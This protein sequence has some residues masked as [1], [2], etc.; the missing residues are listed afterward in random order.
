MDGADDGPP[1]PPARRRAADFVP[2]EQY[3]LPPTKRDIVRRAEDGVIRFD[4]G[5]QEM[6]VKWC[7]E[8]L[9]R[10]SVEFENDLRRLFGPLTDMGS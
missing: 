6:T 8:T 9:R 3:P 10:D 5:V 1:L 4:A 7:D 2:S